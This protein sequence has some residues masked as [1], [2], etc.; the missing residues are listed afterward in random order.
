MGGPGVED[1][2]ALGLRVLDARERRR[3]SPARRGSPRAART[4]VTAA[5]GP[6][7]RST[8]ASDPSATAASASSR[9]PSSR[10]RIAWVSGSPKRQ[11]NSSTLRAVVGQHQPR[12]EEALEGGAAGGQ[13]AEHRPVDRLDEL[14]RLPRRPGRHRRVA[15][16]PA[17]VRAASP[18]SSRLKSCAGASGNGS[19]AVA[20]REERDLLALEQL[21][22]DDLAA[23]RL[24]RAG[25]A[26]SSLGLASRRRTRPSRPRGRRP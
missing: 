8:P 9:S 5:S 12:V 20:E 25:S 15:P 22:D 21:L 19:L 24:R 13:L 1:E 4:T 14:L 17:G 3:R 11:L 26:S 6:A 10:G 18:S 2:R 16:H 7:A 23:E